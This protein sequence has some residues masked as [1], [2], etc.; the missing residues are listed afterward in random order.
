MMHDK[1]KLEEGE[2]EHIHENGL[3]LSIRDARD[4]FLDAVKEVKPEVL[5]DLAGEP[6]KLYKAAGLAFER[7]KYEKE[8][9][10]LEYWDGF[11]A[12]ARLENRHRWNHPDWFGH[13]ENKEVDYDENSERCRKAF[14]IGQK[15]II[16]T[17]IG[18][19]PV[20]MKRLIGGIGLT[21]FMKI[22]FGI[23]K[24]KCNRLSASHPCSIL[25]INHCILSFD[26]EM[27]KKK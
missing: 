20:L 18:V 3:S 7:E 5:D 2:L 13:F 14:S 6:F 9:A 24:R 11:R 15:G 22:A 1:I 25:V 23:M 8:F 10:D 21:V 4:Y 19:A 17:Q 26:S 16:L 27:K 12:M